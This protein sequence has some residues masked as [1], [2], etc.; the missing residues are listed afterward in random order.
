[1]YSSFFLYAPKIIFDFCFD[2]LYFLPW[3]YGRGLKRRLKNAGFFLKRK[4]ETLAIIVWLKNIHQP[5]LEQYGWQGT[6]K[7]VIMRIGQIVLRSLILAFWVGVKIIEIAAYLILPVLVVWE[8]I[9]Q[10]I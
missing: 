9:Y 7:S 2:I 4:E 10:L 6:V 3:W 1:M 8:I 5:L